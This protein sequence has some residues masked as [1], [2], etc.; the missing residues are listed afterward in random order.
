M[1]DLDALE[2]LEALDSRYDIYLGAYSEARV[3]CY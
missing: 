3:Y 1:E 2:C